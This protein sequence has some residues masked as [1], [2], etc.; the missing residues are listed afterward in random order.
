MN[1]IIYGTKDDKNL[2]QVLRDKIKQEFTRRNITD[3]VNGTHIINNSGLDK[4]LTPDFDTPALSDNIIF[5]EHGEKTINLINY[6]QKNA[7]TEYHQG[8]EIPDVSPYIE[9][10]N[11]LASKPLEGSDHGCSLI[12]VGLCYGACYNGCNGCWGS[13]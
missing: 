10:I 12:C 9:I 7:V 1:D 11:N 13:K 2:I 3:T 6:C 4:F 5:G 8:D